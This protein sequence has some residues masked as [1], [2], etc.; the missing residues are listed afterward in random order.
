MGAGFRKRGY[1]RF[2]RRCW[3]FEA[4]AGFDGGG[5]TTGKGGVFWRLLLASSGFCSSKFSRWRLEKCLSGAEGECS[6][7]CIWWLRRAMEV[8]SVV[9]MLAFFQ[10]YRIR[11]IGGGQP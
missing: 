4:L 10:M 9:V 1:P 5:F 6:G 11:A 8:A 3:V 2:G 7:R